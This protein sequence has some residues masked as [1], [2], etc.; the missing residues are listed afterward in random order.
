M[1]FWQ[2]SQRQRGGMANFIIGLIPARSGSQRIKDKNIK[3]LAGHPL[4]VYSI[5][6]AK[7][8]GVFQEIVCSTDSKV[9]G[10]IA[11]AHGVT[12]VMRP[13]EY[14]TADSPDVEWVHHV[15]RVCGYGYQ[16]AWFAILRP[17]SPF[18]TAKTIQTAWGELQ[19]TDCDCLRAVS[20]AKEHPAKM[21]YMNCGE[22]VP[23]VQ[24]VGEPP[25]W[26]SR[27]TQNLPRV[28]VQNASLEIAKCSL[29]RDRLYPTICGGRV[30]GFLN[31]PPEGFDIN[32]QDDWEFAEMKLASG[33]W[34]LPEL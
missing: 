2:V 22:L 33:E 29:V 9:I 12:V 15:L 23:Y 19:R 4:L 18:R 32:N 6:A 27:S 7:Q 13:P 17:T 28:M 24:P 11:R 3:A 20:Y 30:Y 21:W 25:P 34:G 8:S 16:Y 26:H 5:A 1:Y 14:A 31:P 10:E